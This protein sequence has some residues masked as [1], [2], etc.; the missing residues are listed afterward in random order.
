MFHKF[1]AL[2]FLLFFTACSAEPP[3]G[4]EATV[5]FR[6]GDSLGGGG[7]LPV[8]PEASS[9]NGA[10]LSLSGQI[11]KVGKEWIVLDSE[12]SEIWIPIGSILLIEYSNK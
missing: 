4:R 5:Q 12:G 8:G 9:I 1:S 10:K 2:A 6:R 7:G 3:A 11:N